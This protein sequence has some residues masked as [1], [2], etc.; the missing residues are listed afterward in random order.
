ML[1][2]SHALWWPLFI[3]SL[4][5]PDIVILDQVVMFYPSIYFH[6]FNASEDCQLMA[7]EYLPKL[8]DWRM[9]A[10]SNFEILFPK[11]ADSPQLIWRHKHVSTS[12]KEAS[13]ISQFVLLYSTTEA[14]GAQL[15]NVHPVIRIGKSPWHTIWPAV[16]LPRT[17]DTQ[18]WTRHN[19]PSWNGISK[20]SLNEE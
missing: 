5:V 2:S 20:V 12:I 13:G 10:S 4:G 19:R 7:F 14:D 8:S 6:L 9:L 15:Y 3:S 11:K 18:C 16:S 17:I 1:F